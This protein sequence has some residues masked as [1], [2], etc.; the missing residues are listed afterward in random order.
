MTLSPQIAQDDSTK[1]CVLIKQNYKKF[2]NW[3]EIYKLVLTDVL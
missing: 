1:L 2:I 3:W